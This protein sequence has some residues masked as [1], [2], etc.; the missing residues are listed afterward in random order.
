MRSVKTIAFLIVLVFLAACSTYK[1][2]PQ[3]NYYHGQTVPEGFITILRASPAEIEFQIR[4][5]FRAQQLYHLVLD[6]NEPV[7][8]GWFMTTHVGGPF[9][10]VQMK[11]AEGRTYEV[12]KTYRLC[13]GQENPQKVQMTSS[14]Y[15]CMVDLAF[16]FQEKS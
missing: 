3:L 16:V 10:T 13:I 15:Q 9:Y 2:T 1:S 7:A 12:G 6:G 4:V 11:P 14:N 5:D 8:E